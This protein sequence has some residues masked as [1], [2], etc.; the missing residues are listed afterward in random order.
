MTL[1]VD[2]FTPK[3]SSLP[4]HASDGAVS[5]VKTRPVGRTDG[6]T[7][8]HTDRQDIR[9]A[10]GTLSGEEAYNNHALVLSDLH[11]HFPINLDIPTGCYILMI[12]IARIAGV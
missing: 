6:Q 2:I 10:P 7:D 3:H 1:N 4:Q 12:L 9:N 11:S 8:G 5:L